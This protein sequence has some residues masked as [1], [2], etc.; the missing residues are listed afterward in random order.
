MDN[1]GTL[2]GWSE[3]TV[4][5]FYLLDGVLHPSIYKWFETVR[6][7]QLP[8]WGITLIDESQKCRVHSL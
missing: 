4:M 1:L 2:E 7:M 5:V 8:H 3:D 6:E